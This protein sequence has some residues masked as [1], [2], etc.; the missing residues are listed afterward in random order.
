MQSTQN[1]EVLP[2]LGVFLYLE[3]VR[4]Q[5][6]TVADSNFRAKAT[7][8]NLRRIGMLLLTLTATLLAA[9]P[10]KPVTLKPETTWD[11]AVNKEGA[12][13]QFP[14][15]ITDKAKLAEAWK[16]CER[17]DAVPEVDF[18]KKFVVVSTTS[19]S[20]LNVG[21]R[22]ND[23]GDLQVLAIGTRDFRPGFRYVIAVFPR[24]GVKSVDGV[25]LPK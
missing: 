4:P 2:R 11:G 25:E 23:K 21:G 18:S 6:N 3:T 8:M 10:V 17:E 9:D 7:P 20:R 15:V 14:R 13:E 22:L 16:A 19:G 24:E 1:P 12:S 5:S